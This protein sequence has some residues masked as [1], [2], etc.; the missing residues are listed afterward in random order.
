MKKYLKIFKNWRI[1]AI[2]AAF[3]VGVVL[4]VCDGDNISALI[5]S[6]V[7]GALLIYLTACL[8]HVWKDRIKELEVFN[9]DEDEQLET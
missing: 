9:I 4:F 7:I 1:D 5:A 2:A 6:K 8:A 3:T